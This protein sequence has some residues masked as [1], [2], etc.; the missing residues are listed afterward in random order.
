V[1]ALTG[2]RCPTEARDMLAMWVKVRVKPQE[3]ERSQQASRTRS[4]F[5]AA[6]DYWSRNKE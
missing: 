1:T 4:V 2:A 5:P 6:A 3:R